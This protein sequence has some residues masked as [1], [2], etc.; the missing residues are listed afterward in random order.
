MEEVKFKPIGVFKGAQ[1]SPAEAPRQASLA[2]E[3]KGIVELFEELSLDCLKDLEGFTHIWLLYC[4]HQNSTWSPLVRPPRGE[5]K[6]GVFATRSP[7]RPNSIGTSCVR[8]ESVEGRKLYVRDIDLLDQT[9]ILDI[10]PYI[11]YADSIP[12]ASVGWIE[13][14]E[15]FEIKL[16]ESFEKKLKWLEA[17]IEVSLKNLLE[18]HLKYEPTNNK[19][20]RVKPLGKGFVFSYKTWRFHFFIESKEV[21]LFDLLS[22]YSPEEMQSQQDPY[23]DKNIHH[24][25]LSQFKK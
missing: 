5:K 10:K 3:A 17:Q 1:K 13:E 2:T 21:R 14:C 20:K 24:Q 9:P 19:I 16:T 6:R 15:E 18:N 7:Y 4:F 8:L 23:G 25:F 11:S 12:E 22:G